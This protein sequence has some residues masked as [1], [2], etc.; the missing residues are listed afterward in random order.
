MNIGTLAIELSV[1]LAGYT[2]GMSKASVLAQKTSQ[3]ISSSFNRIGGVLGSVLGQFGEFGAQI[4]AQ[5]GGIASLAGVVGGKFNSMGKAFAYVGGTAAAAGGLLLATAGAAVAIAVHASEAAARLYE[6]S[7]STGVATHDLSGLSIVAQLAGV[8]M[9]TLAKGL[10]RLSKNALTAVE[11]PKTAGKAW[12]TLGFTTQEVSNLLHG[13][14]SDMFGAVADKFS[15]MK[16]G[17][18]KTALAM[19]LFGRAG[20]ELIPMLNAGST[21]MKYWIDYG[22]KVGAVLSDEDAANAKAFTQELLKLHLIFEGLENR[23]MTALLPALDHIT[24]AFATLIGNGPA[25][26]G[27]GKMVG[28]A[29]ID[30]AKGALNAVEA[31]YMVGDAYAHAKQYLA[32]FSVSLVPGGNHIKALSDAMQANKKSTDDWDSSLTKVR[33]TL[34]LMRADLTSKTIQA[35]VPEARKSGESPDIASV[36]GKNGLENIDVEN[37]LKNSE[38]FEKAM[39]ERNLILSRM[40]DATIMTTGSIK[41]FDK[42][43]NKQT[44]DLDFAK[45]IMENHLSNL[46]RYSA[47]QLRVNN[48]VKEGYLT[49]K[50][51]NEAL[52][53]EA[54]KLKLVNQAAKESET[55]KIFDKAVTGAVDNASSAMTKILMNTGKPGNLKQVGQSFETS[56]VGDFMKAGMTDIMKVSG[57]DKIF[58]KGKPD[59]TQ[60]NPLHVKNVESGKAAGLVGAVGDMGL[61]LS[62]HGMG[63]AIGAAIGELPL[64]PRGAGAT[65]S[66]MGSA[67]GSLDSIFKNLGGTSGTNPLGKLSQVLSIFGGFR[68]GGGDVMPGKSYMVGENRPEMFVPSVPGR[69]VSGGGGSGGGGR[70]PMMVT[71]HQHIHGAH[72]PESF[73]AAGGQIASETYRQLQVAHARNGGDYGG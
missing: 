36:H 31:A 9:E 16:D 24:A 22:T 72:N 35:P 57:L 6:L 33:D 37:L 15:A 19:Q 8:N 26:Q 56:I 4:Q 3:E 46:D 28:D 66:L 65:T 48:A 64:T 59:G 12:Q 47:F 43:I 30:V 68:A 5:L 1:G 50:A 41:D 27:F 21:A 25:V 67:I 63:S 55:A 2:L 10:E 42:E 29:M 62:G 71:V 32:E 52:A 17:A 51:A 13:S 14:T 60:N 34:A 69:I 61:P 20:A 38:Q 44:S 45:S 11:A 70:G 53:E 23:L 73:R 54:D 39:K 40:D 49:Q 18:E 7:Q 58:G